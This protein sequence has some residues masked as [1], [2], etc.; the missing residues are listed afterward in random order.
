[1]KKTTSP[2]ALRPKAVYD[3]GEEINL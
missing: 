3:S 2:H 1:M